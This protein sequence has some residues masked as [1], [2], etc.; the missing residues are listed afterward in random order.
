[1]LEVPKFDCDFEIELDASNVVV[2]AFR[3]QDSGQVLK[4]VQ[5][6]SRKNNPAEI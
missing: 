6:F 3:M 2:R 4:P 5:Y 1:M